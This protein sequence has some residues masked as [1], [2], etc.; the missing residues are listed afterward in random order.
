ML[1]QVTILLCCVGMFAG[2]GCKKSTGVR[3]AVIP[4]GTTHS[5]WKSVEAGAKKA[6]AEEGLQII[7]QGPLREDEAQSQIALVEQFV[8]DEVNGIVVAPV[9]MN[10]LAAPIGRAMQK[11][12]PVVIFDSALKGSAPKDFVSFVATDNRVGGG[13]AGEEMVRLLGG[14]GTVLLLR[15]KEGHASTGEREEG[16][17]E[18]IRKAPG[19]KLLD[20]KFYL[21]ATVGDA[22]K[23]AENL[24]DTIRQ[25]DAIFC[26]NQSSTEGMLLMLQQN[27]DVAK[28]VK[29]VGFDSS[30][31]IIAALKSG[32]L[33]ASVVQN[34][35][36][37]GYEAVKAISR[38]IKGETV[39]DRV[40]TGCALVT[41]ANMEDPAIKPL[42]V[43]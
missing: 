5:F 23:N 3:I 38:H 8:S 37:M 34:P 42:M 6:G 26:P 25:S 20:N 30:E 24:V 40:D 43:P 12:I 36:K 17:A 7:W 19:I 2:G 39:P 27:A 35:M 14:K 28:K 29:F 13:K 16:F 1:R 4:K 33:N 31:P 32:Q 22:Q 15:Y 9:D 18:A 21:G 11:K 10:A 41:K